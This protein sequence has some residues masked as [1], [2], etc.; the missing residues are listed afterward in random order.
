MFDEQEYKAIFSKVTASGEIH[1]RILNME[2]AEKCNMSASFRKL[3]VIAMMILTLMTFSVT[4]VG[5]ITGAAWFENYFQKIKGE[6]LS[7]SQGAFIDENTVDYAKSVTLNGY[8][9]SVEY[10]LTD[11]F[12]AYIK[13]KLTA[14]EG[15]ILNADDYGFM[16]QNKSRF[17][18]ADGS[19]PSRSTSWHMENENPND[20][21][22]YFPVVCHGSGLDAGTKW[23]LELGDLFK[24]TQREDGIYENTV[25]AEG[26]YRF[27]LVLSE[28]GHESVELLSE[29]IHYT[30]TIQITE[31]EYKEEDVSITSIILRPL[32]AAI[33]FEGD[34]D[35]A[36][37]AGMPMVVMKDGSS[38]EMKIRIGG[39]G[40]TGYQMDVPIDLGEVEHVLLPNGTKIMMPE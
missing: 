19:N 27:E 11:G 33:R 39:N 8:T 17:Y 28:V 2:S 37:I 40:E 1:R 38:V 15:V 18:P 13:V 20:S 16:Y 32:S 14:P 5:A 30:R 29:P 34:E 6:P 23:I 4:A 31:S 10:A 36:A 3:A 7:E 21:T 24:S 26:T 9:V 22:V 25:I 12:V 35:V